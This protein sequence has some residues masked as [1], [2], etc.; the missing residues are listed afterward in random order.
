MGRVCRDV[1]VG[2]V[3][4]GTRDTTRRLGETASRRELMERQERSF[5]ALGLPRSVSGIEPAEVAAAMT[6]DKK[7]V[8][9]RNRLILPNRIGEVGIVSD[10]SEALILEASGGRCDQ[11]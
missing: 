1:R 8:H 7:Y 4:S 10:V 11:S 9:G 3:E 2:W 6:T 5:A